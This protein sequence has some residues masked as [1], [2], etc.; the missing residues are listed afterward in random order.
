[1]SNGS[2]PSF[3]KWLLDSACTSHICIVRK[4]FKT[5]T[6]RRREM[7]VGNTATVS[8]EGGRTVKIQS[9]VSSVSCFIELQDVFYSPGMIL[10]L[11]SC[12]EA[13][14][15]GIKTIIDD[16]NDD[17]SKEVLKLIEKRS[18]LTELVALE[19][20]DSLYEASARPGSA[21]T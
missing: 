17:A 1:M 18:G 12:S 8:A 3:Q 7:V 20:R 13:R 10:N 19:S 6:E 14:R 11:I 5:Y 4:L 2:Q 21:I 9:L 16:C 15:I